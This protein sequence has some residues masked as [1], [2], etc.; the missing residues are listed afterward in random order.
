MDTG[1]GYLLEYCPSHPHATK[2]GYVRQHRLVM[3]HYL[4][5][6]LLADEHVH[7]VD[8]NR[9]NNDIVNLELWGCVHPS[10]IRSDVTARSKEYSG[11]SC[12]YRKNDIVGG[13]IVTGRWV[14]VRGYVEISIPGYPSTR[15]AG[16]MF[17]HRLVMEQLLGRRLL[18]TEEV[19]HLDGNKQNNSPSNLE[20]WERP[21]PKNGSKILDVVHDK[22]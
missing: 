3:E 13:F 6:L 5:R 11:T 12:G 19:H 1:Y 20:L 18:P 7:H 8:G 14:T 10:G 17:E 9:K 22:D 15:P 16:Y 21:H 4:G 2:Q